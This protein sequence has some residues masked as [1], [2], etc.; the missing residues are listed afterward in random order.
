[1]GVKISF[2]FKTSSIWK[3]P[4]ILDGRSVDLSQPFMKSA[5]FF[6]KSYNEVIHLASKGLL[7]FN[8]VSV[9][10]FAGCFLFS[11]CFLTSPVTLFCIIFLRW[12]LPLWLTIKSNVSKWFWMLI[13]G[14]G[15]GLSGKLG[16]TL[17][18]TK[19]LGISPNNSVNLVL[20]KASGFREG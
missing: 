7:K 19:K 16:I 18:S 9:L 12:T 6:E 13:S 15:D 8:I 17:F 3:N 4:K 20:W 11:S 1:M 14:I 2:H 10:T 5:L